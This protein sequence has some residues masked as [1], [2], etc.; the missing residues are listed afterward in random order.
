MLQTQKHCHELKKK[1]FEATKIWAL[2]DW[3]FLTRI[4]IEFLNSQEM[5]CNSLLQG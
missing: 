4:E 3:N 1:V 2:E 5:Y